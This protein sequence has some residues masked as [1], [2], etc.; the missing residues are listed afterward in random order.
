[1]LLTVLKTTISITLGY[2]LTEHSIK[3]LGARMGRLSLN[4]GWEN[5]PERVLKTFSFNHYLP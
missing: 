2:S 1:M 3:A 5:D 4:V